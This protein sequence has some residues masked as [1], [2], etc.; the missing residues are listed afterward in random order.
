MVVSTIYDKDLKRSRPIEFKD[1]SI[2][3]PRK[4]QV[5]LIERIFTK[6]G[7]PLSIQVDDKITD[8][9]IIKL[10]NSLF[11][12]VL[13]VDTENFDDYKYYFLS[14]ARSFLFEMDDNEILKHSFDNFK[15]NI[16]CDKARLVKKY[17]LNHSVSKTFEYLLEEFNFISSGCYSKTS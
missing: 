6:E 15:N 16:V 12:L 4:K 3:V 7:I 5:S 1:I 14:V 13:N 17:M 10:M 9:V 8:S 2:I 11:N